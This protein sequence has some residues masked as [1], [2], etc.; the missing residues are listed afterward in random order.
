[1]KRFRNV[2]RKPYT[3][4]LVEGRYPVLPHKPIP[5]HIEKPYYYQF[6]GKT[7][8]SSAFKGEPSVHSAEFIEKMR[9]ACKIAAEAL[10]AALDAVEVGK[11]T[12]DI[13]TVVHNYIIEQGAYPT[14]VYFMGFPKSVCASVN[15]VLC[16]GIPDT[17]PLKD[18]DYVN[19]DVTCYLDGAYGDTSDMALV[20]NTHP[21]IRHLVETTRR[22]VHEAIGICKPG[23]KFK[24]IGDLISELASNEGYGVCGEF[25]GHGIGDH[26]HMPPPVMHKK[27]KVEVV[28]E[29]GMTFTIEPILMMNP[30]YRLAEWSDGWTVVD[31]FLGPSAQ[32]E[33]TVLITESGAEVLTSR[34]K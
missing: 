24:E 17:R 2:L 7:E 3:E 23:V 21:E 25:S 8:F 31:M 20:G 13:D 15:E 4:P 28:M 34:N 16:H 32:Y 30:N 1:M 9:K 5:D 27:N 12:E 26:L 14:P 6:K 33:H 19:F 29:P 10:Q 18:G 11:S 22:A